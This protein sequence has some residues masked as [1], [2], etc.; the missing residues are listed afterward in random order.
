MAA[1]V[2]T[3]QYQVSGGIIC[4]ARVKTASGTCDIFCCSEAQVY[5]TGDCMQAQC[6]SHCG[7]CTI[8]GQ[9]QKHCAGSDENRAPVTHP[10]ELR[11]SCRMRTGHR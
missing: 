4:A 9:W 6:G 8:S 3:V 11:A 1:T 7:H 10:S 2:D 5:R